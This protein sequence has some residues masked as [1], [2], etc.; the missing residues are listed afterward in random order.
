MSTV[1]GDEP[2]LLPE[3]RPRRNAREAR[4]SQAIAERRCRPGRAEIR[5]TSMTAKAA[6]SFD[7]VDRHHAAQYSRPACGPT[8]SLLP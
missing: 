7:Q 8:G 6:V 5:T 1:F 3:H 4:T 2:R